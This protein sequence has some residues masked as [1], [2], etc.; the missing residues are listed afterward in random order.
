MAEVRAARRHHLPYAYWSSCRCGLL[1]AMAPLLSRDLARAGTV[2]CVMAHAT[3]GL[4][5]L[6][7]CAL[8][9]VR[10]TSLA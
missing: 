4:H 5:A 2:A 10:L 6:P 3:G 8:T 7:G 9:D 1:H